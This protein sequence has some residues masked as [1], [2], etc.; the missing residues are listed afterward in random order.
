MT[1]SASDKSDILGRAEIEILVKSF[2]AAVRGDA[3]LGPVFDEVAKVDWTE[4]LPKICDFWETVL[5]RNG[6]YRGS[7]LAAHLRLASQTE[8]HR[9][10]FDRWLELFDGTINRLFAGENAEHVRRVAADMADVIHSRVREMT[11]F[12]GNA[13]A[14]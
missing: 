9:S 14:S 11:S 2:Y 7:P 10:L 5:F 8:M 3:A 1:E 6:S 12:K 13:P 4:H